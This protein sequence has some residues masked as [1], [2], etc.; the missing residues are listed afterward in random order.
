[1]YFKY[2][3]IFGECI[4]PRHGMFGNI[5]GVHKPAV[6]PDTGNLVGSY[7]HPFYELH[8]FHEM[9]AKKPQYPPPPA[10][11]LI[12]NDSPPPP[13]EEPYID[14]DSPPP[15]PEDPLVAV[16]SNTMEMLV[17]HSLYGVDPID[18]KDKN[19]K[20][21]AKLVG[22]KKPLEGLGDDDHAKKMRKQHRKHTNRV[23]STDNGVG[24]VAC[25]LDK[26]KVHKI[27]SS[28]DDPAVIKALSCLYNVSITTIKDIKGRRTWRST[29]VDLWPQADQ[30]AYH[31]EPKKRRGISNKNR[32]SDVRK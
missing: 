7:L 21:Q 3:S 30:A 31:A 22:G 14:N 6:C 32:D 27:F 23:D 2:I 18:G 29:T 11:P 10:E 8:R 25:V 28:I 19:L 20:K 4:I 17:F 15:P 26:E 16:F 5:A 12:D 1:M 9:M 13:P 24:K